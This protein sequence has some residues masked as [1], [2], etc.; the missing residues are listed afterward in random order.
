VIGARGTL[1]RADDTTRDPAAVK[2]TGLG[3]DAFAVH[4]ADNAAGVEGNATIN[5]AEA[6]AR[7]LVTPGHESRSGVR[8]QSP[9]G[10]LSFPLAVA[11]I[12][13]FDKLR[14]IDIGTWKVIGGWAGSFQNT[15]T[16][17]GADDG[18]IARLDLYR[19]IAVNQDRRPGIIPDRFLPWTG[20]FRKFGAFFACI[21]PHGEVLVVNSGNIRAL[22]PAG[23]L[24]LLSCDYQVEH[25]E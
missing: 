3:V 12:C 6:L 4:K 24:V 15:P 21:S 7:V 14:P 11:A 16:G 9:V 2:V 17:T 23:S 8:C 10:G 25:A 22:Q 18:V 20:L 5:L 19:C 1:E 13:G